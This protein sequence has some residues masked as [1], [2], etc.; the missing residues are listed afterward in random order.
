VSDPR[1]EYTRRRDRWQAV[2]AKGERVHLLISNARLAV[3]GLAALVLWLVV[4]RVGMSTWL[5]ALPAVAFLALMVVHGKVLQRN[6]RAARAY[7]L[8]SRG[9][10]RLDGRWAGGG[11]AGERFIDEHPYARDLDIFGDASLFQLLTVARTE[12][13]EET[14]AAWLRAP[15][16]ID[17]I[18][19]RQLAVRELAPRVDFRED[20]AVLAAEAHV[21]RT[22]ALTDWARTPAIGLPVSAAFP[23]ALVVIVTIALL[24]GAFAGRIESGIVF[25]WLVVHFGV[26]AIWR[27]K[28]H[29][30][31][32]RI[33]L[34]AYELNL[35][36]GLLARLER[37][38]FESA[39]LRALHEVLVTND[40]PPSKRI[41]R[42]Q[43]FV[44]A[45]DSLHNMLFAPI[46]QL[47]LVPSF[48][49]IAIDAWHA[50]HGRA[51][52]GW[53]DSVGQF[54]AF[55]SLAAHA[56]EHPDY[57][58][59]AITAEG[60]VVHAAALAHPLLGAAAVANDVRLGGSAPRVLVVSGSN[61]SGKST[62]LR[63][64]GVNVVL[65]LAGASVRAAAMTV[66][67]VAI[68][69]TLRVEDSLQA[70]HSRFYT[71]ILRIRGIVERTRGPL[72]VLFLLDEILHGTNS[73]DRRIGAEAIVRSL[74]E[75]GAIG[76]I[77]THDLA[78][79]ELVTSLG[80]RARNVHF[81]DRLEDGRMVFDYR[82][83]D[84][85]V[86]RS[87]ALALMRAIGLDV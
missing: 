72:P 70:G 53:L 34:P 17:E 75:S 16:S 24:A 40:V 45:V 67:P 82:M 47:L 37:E 33:D 31:L 85:V 43:L 12:A 63:A 71:E 60:P 42:L 80:G 3:A 55:S 1:S 64:V 15:A 9:L 46:G 57:P 35:L 13:G 65:A 23:L 7:R 32:A 36:A 10:E 6:E 18:S 78:L 27:R 69:A 21:G 58:F 20:L 79:T 76:L 19:A 54:E 29:A 14:L 51:L 4:G 81:E 61:M 84:G 49:G 66:S 22:S 8:Y 26:A 56:Y 52:L 62:L 73:H 11:P 28:V 48:A 74:V 68:G 86:E 5:L 77:T 50:A 41:A 39:R 30:V 83:R 25:V 38:P 44:T 2:M 59:P 87:N